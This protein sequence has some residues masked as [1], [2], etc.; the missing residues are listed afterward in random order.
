MKEK[1][2]MEIVE[3]SLHKW[4]LPRTEELH[5]DSKFAVIVKSFRHGFLE[6]IKHSEV[7]LKESLQP[8]DDNT[9]DDT[10]ADQHV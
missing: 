10:D 9:H 4:M 7:I 8:S 2:I 5:N 6:G 1:D 3:D